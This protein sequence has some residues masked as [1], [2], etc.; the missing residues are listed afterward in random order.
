MFHPHSFLPRAFITL[1]ETRCPR[2]DGQT[3][4]QTDRPTDMGNYRAAIAAKNHE[5]NK[6]FS[7]KKCQEKFPLFMIFC[8][9]YL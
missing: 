8:Y 3:D 5:E 7:P 9:L 1:L 6:R 2:T 4:G